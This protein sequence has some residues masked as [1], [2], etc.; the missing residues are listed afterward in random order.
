MPDTT[1]KMEHITK[2]FPGVRAV[3]DVDLELK[4]REI[5]AL[6]GENGAGKSTLINIL[7]GVYRPDGGQIQLGDRLVHIG[8]PGQAESLGIMSIHQEPALV[9]HMDVASN[10]FLGREF[11][12][13]LGLVQRK[14][15]QEAALEVLK[16]LDLDLDP[17]TPVAELSIGEQQMVGICRALVRSP[18]V[19]VLDEPTGA[20]TR[21]EVARLFALLRRL[22][23]EGVSVLYISHRMEEI[24]ELA[25][26]VTVMRNGRR[27]DTLPIAET[28]TNEVVRMMIGKD[29]E[30]FYP[31]VKVEKGAELL[32]I[33]GLSSD[34]AVQ[35]VSLT[36]HA[37]EVVGIY[38]LVGAGQAEL[39][40]TLVGARQMT[41]GSLFF[42]GQPID[43]QSPAQALRHGIALVP[44]ERRD[45][46]LILPMTV[47]ENITLA[48]LQEWSLGGLIK[49][50]AERR[51]AAEQVEALSIVTSGLNQQVRYLSGGNQQKVVLAK[52][53][54][55][56]SRVILCDEPTRGVDVGAKTE[57]YAILTRLLK[58]GTGILFISSELPE[59]QSLS[60]RILVMFRGRVV[61]D[62]PAK[63][64]SSDEL[65]AHALVGSAGP[66][67]DDFQAMPG[68]G[69][70]PPQQ[71]LGAVP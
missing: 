64:A 21:T 45:E 6:V 8:S 63:E 36:I 7:T 46:G 49:P 57:I 11:T 3:D 24:F 42:E 26:R 67:P 70:A 23:E 12:S 17:T 2:D 37:G 69:L 10:I 20:L 30:D 31:K 58:S 68:H 51:A 56:N 55:H 43:I 5:H 13:G 32:R 35:D 62:K 34:T 47:K 39:A 33:E 41:G 28:D 19:F 71:D 40:Y 38:G 60:D 15:A 59:V 54:A 14:K 52:W 4:P 27:I 29:L 22:R 44:R 25:D 53:L 50:A 66:N 1:V 9:P 65:L 61:L 18:V 48:A 16:R